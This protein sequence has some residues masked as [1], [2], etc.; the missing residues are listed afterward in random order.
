MPSSSENTVGALPYTSMQGKTYSTLNFPTRSHFTCCWT[1]GKQLT[2]FNGIEK[3][4]ILFYF[5]SMGH[6]KTLNL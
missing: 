3:I 4:F 1:Q 2:L 6:V 5:N